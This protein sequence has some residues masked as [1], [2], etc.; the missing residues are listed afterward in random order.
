LSYNNLGWVV[1][2]YNIYVIRSLTLSLNYYHISFSYSKRG[3]SRTPTRAVAS[4][5]RGGGGGKCITR[6]HQVKRDFHADFGL[7][8][9]KRGVLPPNRLLPRP[10][11]QNSSYGPADPHGCHIQVAEIEFRPNVTDS[12]HHTLFQFCATSSCG[13]VDSPFFEDVHWKKINLS[14]KYIL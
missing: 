14:R 3:C 5:W 6:Y 8:I 10:L 2:N 7:N 13:S 9:S 12:R 11:D 4:G 1:Q